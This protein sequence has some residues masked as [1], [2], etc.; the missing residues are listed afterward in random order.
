MAYSQRKT[1]SI[2][3]AHEKWQI[4]NLLGKDFSY[5]KYILLR[6]TFLKLKE[7]ENYVLPNREYQEKKWLKRNEI[8]ILESCIE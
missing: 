3:T 2:E 8:K 4:L 1:Q 5:F 7:S 6:T